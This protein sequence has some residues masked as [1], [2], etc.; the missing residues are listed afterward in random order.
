MHVNESEPIHTL[1]IKGKAEI[2]PGWLRTFVEDRG[3]LTGVKTNSFIIRNLWS[4]AT[5]KKLLGVALFIGFVV[6]VEH[7]FGWVRLLAPWQTLSAG[8]IF[9]AVGLAL[10]SYWTRAMRLYDYFLQDMRGA[11]GACF[12]V[13]LQHNLLNNLLP[14]RT[15]EISFP[16]LMMRHFAV[17]MSR[18]VPALLWFRLLDLHTLGACA[19]LAGLGWAW[20]TVPSALGGGILLLAWMLL[21]LL[22]FWG[23]GH[24]QRALAAPAHP[25]PTALVEPFASALPCTAQKKTAT[26]KFH[27]LLQKTLGSLPQSRS[28]FWRAWA[29]TVITW[30]VKLAVFA[31][32]LLLFID[33]A[34][35]A[36]LMG[37]IAG[38]LTS[39][40]PVH[41][42]AGMGTYEAGVIAGLLP[43]GITPQ[44]ALP[45]AVNLHL[46]LL[47]STLIGGAI[48]LL[49]GRSP[50]EK[51]THE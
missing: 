14:M 15:G 30:A 9:A 51:K 41:G 50:R 36:A 49:L 35:T 44:N 37:V 26:G 43:Y 7:Y 22:L 31:W 10:V 16:L 6:L 5:L 18:S 20:G 28:D 38:D 3:I 29:W 8:Q 48:S 34:P 40:L 23:Q 32:V 24:W 25:A 27:S 39:V 17:P 46:F 2:A 21:P 11:F 4:G 19:L 47:A 12:K 45:A 1:L 13:T 42:V 33:I